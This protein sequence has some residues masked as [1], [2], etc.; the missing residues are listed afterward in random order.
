[1]NVQGSL[2]AKEALERLKEGNRKYMGLA[3][4]AGDISP[5]KRKQTL[6]KGQQPYAIIISCS[7]SRVIPES[8]F[9]AGIGDLFVIRVAG[10]VIDD[11]QLGSIEYAAEHLG[12][13]L[14][15][16][17]GHD[18]CGAV[19]AAI[20]HD[21]EGYIKFITDEIKLA[22]GDEKDD[23]RACCLNVRRSIDM[24]ESS[25]EIHREEE[26]G[27]KVMGALYHLA[28]GSVEFGI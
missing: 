9:S 1:M 24:I 10:N 3:T 2:S 16:V 18:H 26:H 12:A 20:N 14:I 4:A 8:V 21:P 23:Y 19:D 17:L 13:K 5:E 25:F 27:L 7:D 6:K 28:D 22:I 15:L 11:H